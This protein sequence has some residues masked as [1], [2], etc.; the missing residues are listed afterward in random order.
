MNFESDLQEAVLTAPPERPS[1]RRHSR[2]R[3]RLLLL[4]AV[5]A[6]CFLAFVSATVNLTWRLEDR[7]AAI[8]QLGHLNQEIYRLSALSAQQAPQAALMQQWSKI[9][10]LQR[11]E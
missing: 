1:S 10:K 7:A 5:W 3:N 11:Q 4:F 9:E 2:L 6:L 8:R